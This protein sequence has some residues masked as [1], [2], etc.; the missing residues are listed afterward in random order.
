M[1]RFLRTETNKLQTKLVL[2]FALLLGSTNTWADTVT[3]GFEEWGASVADGW[4]LINNATY[5]NSYLYDY[6]V[7]SSDYTPAAGSKCLA[8]SGHSAAQGT[9]ESPMIVTPALSGTITFQFRKYNSSSSTKGY[10]NIF[11]YDE[12]SGKAI[13]NSLWTCRPNGINEATSKYQT[14][15]LT[16][17][18]TPKRLA[19]YLAKVSIDEFTYSPAAGAAEGPALAV[20][21]YKSGETVVFGMINPGATKTL[22]LSNPGTAEV[23]VTATATGGYS[24][25]PATLKI[26]AKSTA[27]LTITVPNATAEGTLTLTAAEAGVEAI[28]LKLSCMVKDPAKL[29]EDFSG[30]KLPDEWETVGIG[31]YTTGEYASSY[32]WDF[33]QGYAAYKQS[34]QTESY[35]DYYLHSLITPRL[36][37]TDNE[38]MLF[39]VKKNVSFSTN[40]GILYV[41]YSADKSSWT[42]ATNGYFSPEAI[43]TEWKDCEVTIPASAKYV[44]F[45]G[46]GIAIDE[47]YG[48]TVSTVPMPKLAVE[49]YTNG[50]TL[51]WGFADV[52]AGTEKTL[53]LKNTGKA[54]LHVTIAATNDFTLSANEATI[55][56]GASFELKIGTPAHDGNG[57]LTITPDAATGLQPFTLTLTSYYKVPKAVMALNTKT[58]SF[59]KCYANKSET[60]TV[61]NTGDATLTATISSDN[62][63]RF[64][65]STATLTVPAGENRTFTITY[66]YDGKISGTFAANITVTPNDGS[67]QTIKATASNKKQGVWSE[68]FEQ[69]IPATWTNDG[70]TIDRK[71]NEESSVNHA[72]A[73]M[74][75]GYLITP[76]LKA[77]E[78]EE[79]SFDFI[80]NYATLKVEYANNIS[81]TEWTLLNNFEE[82]STIIFKAPA[83]GIYYLRFSGS[84]S[85]LDN[86]E[87]FQLDLLPAD[88]IITASTLPTTGNQYAVYTASVTV[89]NKGSQAQT[90]VA[91]L[92]VNNEL[93]DMKEEALAIESKTTLTLNFKP[94]TVL[95]NAAVRIEVTLKDV[96]DFTARTVEGTLN[97][98]AAPTLAENE[99]TTLTQGTLPVAIV[100]YT[101]MNGWNTICMPFALTHDLMDRLF[102]DTWRAYE[103]TGYENDTIR[104]QEATQ[105]VAGYP[106]LVNAK[107]APVNAEGIVVEN[108]IISTTSANYDYRNG[109]TFQGTFAPI[110]AGLMTDK[111]SV[112]ADTTLVKG[113]ETA[114]LLGYRGYFQLAESITKLPKLVFYNADGTSTVGIAAPKAE[115]VIRQGVYNLKG[116]RVE[117]MRKGEI[118]I[119]GGKKT[120]MK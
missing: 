66:L 45:K 13:G 99:S 53:T 30:L 5:G 37:F 14:A 59:G 106:Y 110:E 105:F 34:A 43:T 73:G 113:D 63:A 42:T 33:S 112:S 64:S 94:Q 36:T 52:P 17:G 115:T 27:T 104:M 3:E 100:R 40:I 2:L 20:S 101:A 83:A 69:G 1:N 90:A 16:V 87:G 22:T 120:L 108:L 103:L 98:A 60:I 32:Y 119:I 47:V 51:S 78:G 44:R 54:E 67:A 102:G 107:N 31:S 7:G 75:S 12:E 26:A 81:A 6:V 15:S 82:D 28:T 21:G 76:R 35:V 57:T 88:A 70:W 23:N 71:W 56:A 79:L 117:Q 85:Y 29:Y 18:D 68:D 49:G 74:N 97:V 41:E 92:F 65:V 114:T 8:N 111:Y 55:A 89:E 4:T 46:T 84:G 25:N 50:G 48:G 19:I 116:Q 61:S 118:Y 11:E 80:G 72:Y 24:A 95:E 62:T 109:I 91:K 93:K 39:K 96:S 38:K 9:T 58:V 77:A 10:I 86:F